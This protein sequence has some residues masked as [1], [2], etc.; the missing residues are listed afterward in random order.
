MFF[1]M[2]LV[3]SGIVWALGLTFVMR[4]RCR[5]DIYNALALLFVLTGL[6]LFTFLSWWAGIMPMEFGNGAV[7]RYSVSFPGG[8]LTRG[9]LGLAIILLGLDGIFSPIL[10][11]LFVSRRSSGRAQY[12]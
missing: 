7:V 3:F 4:T 12:R 8:Y 6:I 2:Y 11:A 1:L 9:A 5:A 10:A